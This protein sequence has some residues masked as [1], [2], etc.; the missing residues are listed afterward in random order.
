MIYQ[1]VHLIVV[2]HKKMSSN[3]MIYL[4]LYI[5]DMLIVANNITEINVWKKLLSKE[6]DMKGL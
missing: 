4:R 2:Y 1:G 6:F 5:D 3:T